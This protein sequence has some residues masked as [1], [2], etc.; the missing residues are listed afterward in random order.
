VKWT[1]FGIPRSAKRKL[2]GFVSGSIGDVLW[3]LFIVTVVGLMGI[4][5]VLM[6]PVGA[7]IGGLL[8]TT[9]LSDDIRTLVAD[10][11]Y[12]RWAEVTIPF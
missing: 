7:V 9:L 6:G 2:S 4:G 12:R 10:L 8:I 3:K 1:L 5:L 11:W